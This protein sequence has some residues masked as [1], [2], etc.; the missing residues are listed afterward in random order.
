MMYAGSQQDTSV[1]QTIIIHTGLGLGVATDF[2]N[3]YLRYS[4]LRTL[5]SVRGKTNLT[6]LIIQHSTIVDTGLFFVF[7]FYQLCQMKLA[8]SNITANMG[9]GATTTEQNVNSTT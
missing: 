7:C 9:R 5:I 2:L 6:N 3:Q 4:T 8:H 1:A